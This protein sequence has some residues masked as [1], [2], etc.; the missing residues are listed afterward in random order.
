MPQTRSQDKTGNQQGGEPTPTTDLSI[1]VVDKMTIKDR[2]SA[3]L[4]EF[5]IENRDSTKVLVFKPCSYSKEAFDQWIV[6]QAKQF[7]GMTNKKEYTHA[8]LKSYVLFTAKQ[9]GFKSTDLPVNMPFP[10]QEQIQAACLENKVVNGDLWEALAQSASKKVGTAVYFDVTAKNDTDFPQLLLAM[11][12]L[13]LDGIDILQKR[14]VAVQPLLTIHN[15][16]V[17][18]AG[19]IVSL[20]EDIPYGLA[21]I[22]DL[23]TEVEAYP[24]VMEEWHKLINSLTMLNLD[25]SSLEAVRLA[26][27]KEQIRALTSDDYEAVIEELAKGTTHHIIFLKPT[28]EVKIRNIKSLKDKITAALKIRASMGTAEAV[29]SSVTKTDTSEEVQVL[30]TTTSSATSKPPST[31][32]EKMCKIIMCNNKHVER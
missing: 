8:F 27:Y 10:Q 29:V 12:S 5:T 20:Q 22:E 25:V 14:T 23:K 28:S 6:T 26:G 7:E 11:L 9:L 30:T 3:F 16:L 13:V 17:D 31:Q 32:Y 19:E 21:T 15:K 4:G 1:V 2:V 24:T 18:S